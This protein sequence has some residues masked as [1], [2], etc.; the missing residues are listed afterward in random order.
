MKTKFKIIPV[1]LRAIIKQ[2]ILFLI[3]TIYLI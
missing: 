1:A 2:I 3:G